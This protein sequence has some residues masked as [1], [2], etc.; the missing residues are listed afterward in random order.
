M[1][2]GSSSTHRIIRT[3]ED[4]ESLVGSAMTPVRVG[5]LVF[6]FCFLVVLLGLLLVRATLPS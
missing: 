4:W 2:E 1:V 3:I 6:F 5:A